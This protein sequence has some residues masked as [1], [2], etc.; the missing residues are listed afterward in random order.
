MDFWIEFF[1]EIA[2]SNF[3]YDDHMHTAPADETGTHD[4][5]SWVLDQLAEH[6]WVTTDDLFPRQWV[7]GLRDAGSADFAQQ[8]FHVAGIGRDDSFQLK[9]TMRGDSIRWV[10]HGHPSPA[11]QAFLAWAGDLQQT[12][13][14]AFYTGLRQ[15]EVHF[16]RY[17]AG[18]R[19]VR[20]IDQHQG[21]QARSISM[22]LYLNEDWHEEDGGQ[23]CIYDPAEPGHMLAKVLPLA[24]RLALFRSDLIPHEV[25]PAQRPRW[26]LTGWF[27]TDEKMTEPNM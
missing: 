24:G 12:L 10:E 9:K 17:G 20:H 22:V 6:G 8:L 16:A 23:L 13:N 18:Q 15:L 5:L 26:S 27:R 2:I 11:V 25:L 21:T 4:H 14:A 3:Y 7:A 1:A 19:Y